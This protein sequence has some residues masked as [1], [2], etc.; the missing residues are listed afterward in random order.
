M[1]SLSAV[2]LNKASALAFPPE[3]VQQVRAPSLDPS[4]AAIPPFNA[5]A[6]GVACSFIFLPV[7]LQL[8]RCV[9]SQLFS[10]VALACMCSV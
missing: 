4:S 3:S 6:A 7:A 2:G 1:G 5:C 9:A 10:S 8:R